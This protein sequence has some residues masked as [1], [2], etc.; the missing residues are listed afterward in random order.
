MRNFFVRYREF[1]SYAHLNQLLERWLREEADPRIHGTVR[2]VV[3]ARFL[4]EAP[5]LT[6]PPGDL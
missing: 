6:P 2:E 4:R 1:E 3:A 5:T